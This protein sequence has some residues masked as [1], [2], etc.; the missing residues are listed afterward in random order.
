MLKSFYAELYWLF[1]SIKETNNFDKFFKYVFI[2]NQYNFVADALFYYDIIKTY[3]E[4]FGKENIKI[5]LFE[6]LK[7]DKD[8]F[9][10]KLSKAMEINFD[11]TKNI[12]GDSKKNV[13]IFPS[14]EYRLNIN[15][16]NELSKFIN[17]NKYINFKF[18]HKLYKLPPVY[19]FMNHIK[20]I[21]NINVETIKELNEEQKKII[22]EIYTQSNRLLSKEY[23]LG[24]EKSGYFDF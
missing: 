12:I 23:N 19:N 5:F 7:Y 8:I 15:L 6:E 11:E 2:E 17:E 22:N 20:N 3:K 1:K 4:L 9:L 24:L 16:I 18:I 21:A 13:R 14:G 10:N